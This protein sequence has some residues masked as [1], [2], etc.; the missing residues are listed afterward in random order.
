MGES[1]SS[2][3]LG[4]EKVFDERYYFEVQ[5]CDDLK[6]EIVVDIRYQ[7]ANSVDSILKKTGVKIS[8]FLKVNAEDFLSEIKANCPDYLQTS[9]P[10]VKASFL[11]TSR[12]PKLLI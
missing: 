11:R 4:V 1:Y 3:Q 12:L 8:G 10:E 9:F 6:G 5:S 2:A 7:Q